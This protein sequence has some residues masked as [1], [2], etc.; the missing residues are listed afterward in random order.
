MVM[1]LKSKSSVKPLLVHG[2]LGELDVSLCDEVVVWAQNLWRSS[3]N[4]V[5]QLLGGSARGFS[6]RH[7]G[8]GK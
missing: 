3:Y 4:Q 7:Q 2:L 1:S 8:R 6:R 5:T